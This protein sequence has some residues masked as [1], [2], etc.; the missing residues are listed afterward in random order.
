MFR[1]TKD[2]SDWGFDEFIQL[3]ELRDPSN[4]YIVNDACIVEVEFCLDSLQ[5]FKE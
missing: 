2:E 5:G 3:K 1:F 4:G